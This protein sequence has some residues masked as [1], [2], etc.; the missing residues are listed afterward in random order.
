MGNDLVSV[1]TPAYNA[2]QYVELAIRSVY[3]QS[4]RPIESIVVDDASADDTASIVER[5]A[6]ELGS[7]EFRV[8]LIRHSE[9]RRAAGAL[10]TGFSAAAG[11]WVCWLSADDEY[12]DPDKTGRQVAAMR[13]TGADVSYF[14]GALTGSDVRSARQVEW[15]FFT[16]LGPFNRLIEHSSQA[17][18]LALMFKN[19]INGSSSMMRRATMLPF[20]DALGVA[21]EDSC[22]WLRS[23]A[24]GLRFEPLSGAPIFYRDHAKQTTKD[25]EWMVFG[26]SVTRLRMLRYLADSRR[27]VPLLEANVPLL[28]VLPF[29]DAV[30]WWPAVTQWLCDYVLDSGEVSSA[31]VKRP[32]RRALTRLDALDPG[33]REVSPELEAYVARAEA[34]EVFHAFVARMEEAR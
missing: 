12:V 13:R 17:R 8:R 27:L 32:M 7:D 22:M 19:P 2:E 14:R 34:S 25:R 1:V 21:D 29:S 16:R 3:R 18:L 28:N 4:W 33:G 26:G 11:T 31:A 30:A 24:M 9:R 20:D 10:R 6:A 5:L 23:S 15:T